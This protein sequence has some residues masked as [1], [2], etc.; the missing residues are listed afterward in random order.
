LEDFEKYN[1]DMLNINLEEWT[2]FWEKNTPPGMKISM[3]GLLYEQVMERLLGY[4]GLFFMLHDQPDLVEA[5]FNK[6]GQIM[7]DIYEQAMQCDAVGMIFHGDDMGH[8]T[9]TIINPDHLRKYFFPWLKKYAELAHSHGK[10][11]WLH[12]CGN[13]LAV[14]E[15]LI[16]DVKID[17]FHS[18]QEE[19]IPVYEF[20]K[21]YG[22]RIATLGGVDVDCLARMD[23][24]PL[25]QYCRK[26]LD[27]CMPTRYAFGSG[28]SITNYIP[29]QNYFI[30]M[31]EA[32][33]WKA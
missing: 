10:M 31:D 13:V 19:I 26:I 8:K 14:M 7:Y 24:K 33:N 30:M 5:V 6:W 4:E 32:A 9:G 20:K 27:E 25:R 23:E 22:D 12:S 1:W 28:N 16:E 15:D 21:R 2:K 11:F 17:A 18:F 29:P 3:M